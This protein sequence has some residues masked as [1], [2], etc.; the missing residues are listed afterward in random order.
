MIWMSVLLSL[1]ETFVLVGAI[2][3][4]GLY[5][6][7]DGVVSLPSISKTVHVLV[8]RLS[9]KS[10][11]WQLGWITSWISFIWFAIRFLSASFYID[12]SMISIIVLDHLSFSWLF[13]YGEIWQ[14]A[15]ISPLGCGTI[16]LLFLWWLDYYHP[17]YSEFVL[18]AWYIIVVYGVKKCG[19]GYHLFLSM[20]LWLSGID[21]LVVIFAIWCCSCLRWIWLIEVWYFDLW[22]HSLSRGRFICNRWSWVMG[23]VLLDWLD[24]SYLF[25]GKVFLL[26]IL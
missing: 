19:F 14:S 17:Y 20:P 22:L 13:S 25:M 1:Y 5:T 26:L 6:I 18:V 7:G 11:G 8:L 3:S 10:P 24:S 12:K 4:E 2:H 21:E 15:W 9:G 16:V 23:V